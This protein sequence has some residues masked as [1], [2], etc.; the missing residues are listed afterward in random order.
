ME[1]DTNRKPAIWC[2]IEIIDTKTLIVQLVALASNILLGMV[3]IYFAFKVMK[4]REQKITSIHIYIFLW[5]ICKQ[6]LKLDSYVSKDAY[7][8]NNVS[9]FCAKSDIRINDSS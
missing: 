8:Y 7:E 5:W 2:Q 4:E 9:S 1:I 6:I 3:M